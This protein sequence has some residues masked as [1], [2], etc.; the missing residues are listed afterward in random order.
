MEPI[1]IKIPKV[2]GYHSTLYLLLLKT[3]KIKKIHNAE[4]MKNAI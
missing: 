4:I 2:V 1:I 3:L